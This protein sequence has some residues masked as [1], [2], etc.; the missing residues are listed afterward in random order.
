MSTPNETLA[1]RA[2]LLAFTE[3]LNSGDIPSIA[4]H[5]T[6]DGI[7]FPDHY[8]SIN[9]KKMNSLPGHFFKNNTF[10]IQFHIKGTAIHGDFAFVESRATAITTNHDGAPALT[11]ITRD[12]FT[13]RY[14]DGSWKIYRY[15]FHNAHESVQ[16][17]TSPAGI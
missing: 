15:V 9:R 16:I 17:S 3:A 5:Y 8:S 11:K 12:L 2:F 1:I 6:H 7:F 13:L 10:R 14:T 4:S